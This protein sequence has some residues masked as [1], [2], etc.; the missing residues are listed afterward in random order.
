MRVS[1]GSRI[2][3]LRRCSPAVSVGGTP[4]ELADTLVDDYDIAEVLHE[5]TQHCLEL[6]GVAAAGLMLSDQRGSLQVLASSTE[7]TRLLELFQLQTNEGPCLDCF[8]TGQPV[9]IADI[10][11]EHTRWPVFAPEVAQEGFHSVHAVP[12]RLRR[13]VIGALNLFGTQPGPLPEADLRVAQA[14][15][16]TATIGILSERT[17]RRGEVLTEQLQTALNNRVTIEQAKGLLAH[18]GNLDMD[19]SLPSPP[20]LRVR[21]RHPVIRDR[22]PTCHRHPQPCPHPHPPAD[23]LTLSHEHRH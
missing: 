21:P 14:L 13:D 3:R 1:V 19:Q 9:L 5:L 23:P 12:L 17:I 11:A 2:Q 10:T 22:P 8:R 4:V 15:A 18:A 16:D 20:Q 6:L 7:R